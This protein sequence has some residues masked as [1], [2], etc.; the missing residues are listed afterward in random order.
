M[1]DRL[2]VVV[3][4]YNEEHNVEP[5][6]ER[7]REALQGKVDSF[8]LIFVDDG[9]TDGTARVVK[10]I[11]AKDSRVRL[12]RLSRN[13]GHQ[14]A[15]LAGL[16]A[17]EG[18]AVAAMDADLQHPPEALV[19]MI[20]KWRQ[21]AKIVQAVRED[22][23][24]LP[25]AKRFTSWAFY[26]L[27]NAISSVE[28]TPG[29]ADFFLVDKQV[30]EILRTCPDTGRF[31]RGM[32]GWLGFPKQS[33]TYQC[34]VRHS[35]RSKYSWW[36]MLRFAFDAVFT[37]SVVPLRI[38]GVLGLIATA[39]ALAYLVYAVAAHLFLSQTV[40]GWTSTVATV[41]LMSGVQ[42]CVLSVMGEYLCRIR[43]DVHMRPPYVVDYRVGFEGPDE[44]SGPDQRS[45]GPGV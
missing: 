42:M 25:F 32:L 29:A 2:S 13:F 7:C 17:A 14:A 3:P 41:I 40:P 36:T 22:N 18:D 45:S 15:L 1:S 35:G 12:V 28:V 27:I 24:V 33:I 31:N 4:A 43:E 37:F 23:Q 30:A 11:H 39:L 16:R 6:Y 10:Q 38:V 26:K 9:S 21:N 8:E 34:G 5:L 20:E 19:Q 44:N